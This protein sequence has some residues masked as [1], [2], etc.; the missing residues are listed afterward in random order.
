MGQNRK[1]TRHRTSRAR[2]QLQHDL[3]TTTSNDATLSLLSTRTVRHDTATSSL[4]ALLSNS[5]DI[6]HSWKPT[7]VAPPKP[8]LCRQESDNSR[9]RRIFGGE[10]DETAS[11]QDLRVQ[12]LD[13][14]LGLFNGID[15]DDSMC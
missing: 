4:M 7:L 14:V 6:K 8:K 1:R 2:V 10:D 12:M 15:Y 5:D 11:A 9:D 13:V 3:S